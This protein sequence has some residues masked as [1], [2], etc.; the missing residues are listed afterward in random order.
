M[1]EIPP[2][3]KEDNSNPKIPLEEYKSK[4]TFLNPDKI[5]VIKIKIDGC[6]IKKNDPLLRCDYMMIIL[7][8]NTKT[9]DNVEIYVELKGCDINHAVKQIESTIK[10]LSENPNKLKKVCFVV[11]TSSISPSLRSNMQ[12][13]KSRFKKNFSATLHIDKTP[14]EY[15]LKDLCS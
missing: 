15:N 12:N 10:D 11:A 8:K 3:C 14:H 4:I 9:K 2:E 5:T 6:V 1:R 13:Q 7:G